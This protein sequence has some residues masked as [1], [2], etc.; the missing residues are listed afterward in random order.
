MFTQPKIVLGLDA[1]T[2]IVGWAFA[3]SGSVKDAG[4]L[5]ISKLETNKEKG[6]FVIDFLSKHFLINSVD[7]INLEAALSGFGG[8]LT[9]QQTIITLSRWNA[10]F[11]YMLS[12]YF[13]FPIVLC[14]VNTMRKKIFGKARIK[15]IKPKEYVKQQIPL[16]VPNISKFEK[17][18]RDSN[19][20]VHNSDMYD[21]VV[22][23]LFR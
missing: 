8:G 4:F 13:K 22:T 5:N 20:D 6:K 2:S 15:G 10:V 14:N 11:E 17:L 21:A 18:N 3:E 23:S 12:E 7:H 1:S 16:V 9:S 19:W